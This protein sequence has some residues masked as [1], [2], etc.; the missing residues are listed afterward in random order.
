M[1]EEEI[2]EVVKGKNGPE[3]FRELL[4]QYPLVVLDDYYKHGLWQNELMRLDIQILNAHR[5]E[6]GAPDL[7]PLSDIRMLEI[8]E[9][10]L[11]P[12]LTAPQLLGGMIKPSV[13]TAAGGLRPAGALTAPAIVVPGSA[14]VALGTAVAGPAATA[15]TVV[16]HGVVVPPGVV[17]PPR[18]VA[19]TPVVSSEA[20]AAD[21]RQIALFI[22]KWR[23]D[24]T[25][26]SAL[27]MRLT[28]L[29]RN[30]VM[31]NFKD[32]TLVNGAVVPVAK[33]AEYIIQ[34]D[35][36]GA[37]A[38]L[39]GSVPAKAPA[40]VLPAASMPA[41]G[42]ATVGA[43]PARAADVSTGLAGLKRTFDQ[44]LA[45][46]AALP[47]HAGPA[48]QQPPTPPVAKLRPTTAR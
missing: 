27:L 41:I 46:Q 42:T 34:C 32:A 22:S 15:Q 44:T 20:A 5:L 10:K 17:A 3:L 48:I 28:P 7:P 18:P 2:K 36:S 47:K 37:W 30:F 31:Q 11:L 39:E 45:F 29:R 1:E 26:T 33:L 14:Q 40:V 12:A 16:Q 4:R 35:R 24:P 25:Q 21:L 6:A 38:V 9:P 23:L 19:A 8:P 43:P 13:L